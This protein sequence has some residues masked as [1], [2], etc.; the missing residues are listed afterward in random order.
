MAKNLKDILGL[1]EPKTLNGATGVQAKA[2]KKTFQATLE[3]IN[4]SINFIAAHAA[5]QQHNELASKR[6]NAI[7]AYQTVVKKIDPQN[8]GA[9]EAAIDRV[10]ASVSRLRGG[11]AA[12]Q[13]DAAKHHAAWIENEEKLDDVAEQVA[14]M[15]EW[16]YSG[17]EK[18][19]AVV[20]AI[21]EQAK[22][23]KYNEALETLN[24]FLK[25]FQPI[26]DDFVIQR[27]AKIDYEQLRD[28]NKDLLERFAVANHELLSDWRAE[29][30]SNLDSVEMSVEV[31]H[32]Y[33]ALTTLE[34]E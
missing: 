32:F 17:S 14:E 13:E 9:S 28:D 18:L 21:R 7:S 8:P 4:K 30:Q 27:D 10:S 33:T 1:G 2:F 12:L 15:V 6:D 3:E 26:H 23:R 11:A 31:M 5:S 29:I 34:P 19:D 16:G 20:T 25:K 22:L 24:K